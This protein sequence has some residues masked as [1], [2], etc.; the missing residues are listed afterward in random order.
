MLDADCL[1]A[2]FRAV[3][4]GIQRWSNS[5]CGNYLQC[6]LLLTFIRKLSVERM[7]YDQNL[8]QK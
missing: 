2:G 3:V 8:V 4:S 6:I 1:V 5:L 7:C